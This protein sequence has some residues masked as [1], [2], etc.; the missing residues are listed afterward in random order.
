MKS[1][2]IDG[3]N[4]GV[5]NPQWQVAILTNGYSR[6]W[7]RQKKHQKHQKHQNQRACESD[8]S[9]VLHDVLT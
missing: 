8:Q 4:S 9:G 7:R 6:T 2:R 1:T 5:L 3:T